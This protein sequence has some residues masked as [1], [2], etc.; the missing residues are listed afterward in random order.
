MCLFGHRLT[1]HSLRA[2]VQARYMKSQLL[3]YSCSR[4][5]GCVPRMIKSRHTHRRVIPSGLKNV[6]DMQ[7]SGRHTSKVKMIID[8]QGPE[9]ATRPATFPRLTLYYGLIF[10]MAR[11]RPPPYEPVCI[12]PFADFRTIFTQDSF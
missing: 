10:C 3:P 1:V 2:T 7:R 9:C 6:F 8:H 11:I 12:D 4:Q 5:S